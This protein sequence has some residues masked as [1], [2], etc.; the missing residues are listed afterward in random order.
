MYIHINDTSCSWGVL[1][2]IPQLSPRNPNEE[3]AVGLYDPDTREQVLGPR[4]PLQ[5]PS[6]NLPVRVQST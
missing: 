3:P 2:G 4:V 1:L 5:K 6:Q